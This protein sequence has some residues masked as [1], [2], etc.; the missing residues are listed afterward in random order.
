MSAQTQP[1][2]GM[3][4]DIV[5]YVCPTVCI[6]REMELKGSKK[7]AFLKADAQGNIKQVSRDN[8]PVADLSTEFR[9]RQ[10]L[11]RRSLA[12][13]QLQLMS[14]HESERYH[15]YLLQLLIQPVPVTHNPITVQQLLDVD[16]HIFARVAEYTRAG[17][18]VTLSGSYPMEVSLQKALT[19]PITL[20]MLQPLPRPVGSSSSSFNSERRTNRSQQSPYSG[21]KGYKGGNPKGYKGGKGVKGGKGSKGKGEGWTP[22]ELAGQ[23]KVNRRVCFNYNLGGCQAAKPGADC[24]KGAHICCKCGAH[25]HGFQS[26]PNKS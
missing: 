19:D 3:E 18:S 17:L 13:D 14:Y 21:H 20:S 26:C 8:L 12:L 2:K 22:Q 10:A 16:K 24:R 6:S 23:V 15:M 1:R 25:D 5:R 4:D 9:L 11:Q 7:E